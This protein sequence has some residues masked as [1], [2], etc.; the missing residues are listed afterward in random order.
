MSDKNLSNARR[1]FLAASSALSAVGLGMAAPSAQAATKEAACPPPK[2]EPAQVYGSKN[3]FLKQVQGGQPVKLFMWRKQVR[4]RTLARRKG[5]IVFVHGSSV[6]GVPA[7]DLRVPGKPEYSVMDYFARLG[8]DTWCPDME[9]YGLSDKSRDIN[10]DINNGVDDLLVISNY[11]AQATGQKKVMYYGLS[12]GALRC[13]V[14]AQRYP[15]RVARLALDAMVWTG[16]GSPTLEARK[17]R[18]E[19]W[20]GANRRPIDKAM[21]ESIFTRDNPNTSEPA[22]VKAFA[23]Q[24]LAL[25]TTMPTGTYLD[26][27]TKLPVCDPEKITVPTIVMRGQFDGIASIEDVLAF[28]AKLPNA[29]KQFAMMPG[30]AHSSLHEINKDI[31]FAII[32]SFFGQPA[33]IYKG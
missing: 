31:P 23:E 6:S 32:D 24:I 15:D 18:V 25:D 17:K 26:M 13:A 27:T 4:D 16:E 14:F 19:E 20:R 3:F 5:V 11:I 7:F 12:S 21:I 8:Y 33:P 1:T 2:T 10:F 22:V 28:Y 29:D 9:G 30:I